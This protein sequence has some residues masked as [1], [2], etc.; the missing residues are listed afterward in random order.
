MLRR[1]RS[2]RGN[3]FGGGVSRSLHFEKPRGHNGLCPFTYQQYRDAIR[4]G[5]RGGGQ[6]QKPVPTEEQKRHP[7]RKAAATVAKTQA[8]AC[9]TKTQHRRTHEID[10][11]SLCKNSFCRY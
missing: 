4:L 2:T 7:V 10:L 5:I 8:E 11:K 3:T 1:A 9:V 6:P